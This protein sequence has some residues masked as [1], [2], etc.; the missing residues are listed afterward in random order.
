M[1]FAPGPN[2]GLLAGHAPVVRLVRYST[3]LA[4]TFG[5]LLGPW[6][7]RATVE[8]PWLDNAPD[9]SCFP[10]GV[11]RVAWTFSPHFGRFT[12]QVLDVPGRSGIR[13]HVAN[14][15]R[16]LLG[17]VGL[18]RR[19]AKFGR[20]AT[21]GVTNSASTLAEVEKAMGRRPFILRV[22]APSLILP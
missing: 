8:L 20:P 6:G 10:L 2:A 18:G 14:W 21:W 12:Y 9:L 5:A 22:S 17:C 13:L 3:G 1:G 7:S 16:N 11:Y 19:V 15:P 4:G